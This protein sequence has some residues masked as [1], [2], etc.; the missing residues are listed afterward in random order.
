M[1][2]LQDRQTITIH[3]TLRRWRKLLPNR[4]MT[5]VSGVC[6]QTGQYLSF[7]QFMHVEQYAALRGYWPEHY[8][9]VDF[10][11]NIYE[12]SLDEECRSV[13]PMI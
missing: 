2:R 13:G 6:S 3:F 12:L 9:G 10:L 11:G 8:I 5:Y 7:V 1:G 4:G